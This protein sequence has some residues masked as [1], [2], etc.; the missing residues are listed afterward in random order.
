MLSGAA[1]ILLFLA[2]KIDFICFPMG[3]PSDPTGISEKFQYLHFF[4]RIGNFHG[5]PFFFVL[6]AN[7]AL[8]PKNA[9]LN[10][11]GGFMF[12]IQPQAVDFPPIL[13][14]FFLCV[15]VF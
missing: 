7:E 11:S 14:I 4:S 10:F 6:F 3:F 9:Q 13:S 2:T 12:C 5:L 8:A 1:K 15:F